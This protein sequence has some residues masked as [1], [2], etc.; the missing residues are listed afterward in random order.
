MV[1]YVASSLFFNYCYCYWYV[2]TMCCYVSGLARSRD[3]CMSIEV[4]GQSC[5]FQQSRH[6]RRARSTRLCY[7]TMTTFQELTAELRLSSR[8]YNACPMLGLV[9]DQEPL[10][11][12]LYNISGLISQL[13]RLDRRCLHTNSSPVVSFNFLNVCFFLL[14]NFSYGCPA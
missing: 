8:Q 4:F 6:R 14:F 9:F 12:S 7:E 3:G 5:R 13:Q 10:L 11:G 2:V 1:C